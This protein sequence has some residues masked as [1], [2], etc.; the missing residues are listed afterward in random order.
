MAGGHSAALLPREP[1]EGVV[2]EAGQTVGHLGAVVA[3]REA[4]QSKV[5][6]VTHKLQLLFITNT[7]IFLFLPHLPHRASPLAELLVIATPGEVAVGPGG[8]DVMLSEETLQDL[9]VMGYFLLF[10]YYP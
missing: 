5:C 2:G 4:G 10:F 6:S 9:P 3:A 8:D 7:I 1:V